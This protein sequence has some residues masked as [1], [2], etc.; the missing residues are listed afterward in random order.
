M[1]TI[2]PFDANFERWKHQIDEIM[3]RKFAINTTD[4]GLDE[5]ELQDYWKAQLS[6][7]AFVTWFGEKYDLTPVSDW[8]WQSLKSKA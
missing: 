8:N 6:A 5:N 3:V 4:A 7:D 2:E 1:S